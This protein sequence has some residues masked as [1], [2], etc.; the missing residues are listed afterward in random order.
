M[1][2]I[3]STLDLV[4]EKTRHLSMTEEEKMLQ[5]KA[6]FT[7][8]LHGLL[9]QYADGA[10]S[11]NSLLKQ[12]SELAEGMNVSETGQLTEAV[13]GRIDPGRDNGRWLDLL[14]A[15]A[16]SA[17]AP[18]Q[19]ALAEHRAKRA[20]LLQ[21]TEE[22]LV[23]D[24]SEHHDIE[25]SAVIPNPSKDSVFLEAIA[26]LQAETKAAIDA[27]STTQKRGKRK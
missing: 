3:K 25:G 10:F 26:A 24:L 6:D 14:G 8:R 20:V 18:L 2:E 5:K 12:V 17:V 16:T 11:S 21:R 13:I 9:Q 23:K 15:V 27:I 1:G 22:Q 4:M 19:K 7:R